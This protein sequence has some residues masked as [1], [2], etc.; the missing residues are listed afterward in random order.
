MGLNHALKKTTIFLS[1]DSGGCTK[2]QL[3]HNPVSYQDVYVIIGDIK[4]TIA[5]LWHL[6]ELFKKANTMQWHCEEKIIRLGAGY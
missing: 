3:L 6:S 4:Q 2:N 1:T 5:F